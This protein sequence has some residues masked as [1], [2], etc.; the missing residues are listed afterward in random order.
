MEVRCPDCYSSSVV[1]V[2]D[3][4]YYYCEMCSNTFSYPLNEEDYD[5]AS[6]V[7]NCISVTAKLQ[8]IHDYLKDLD[9]WSAVDIDD[10]YEYLRHMD[11]S[12]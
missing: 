2:A 10:L 12:I 6:Y 4:D 9:D 11:D 3:E 1:R 8:W 7:S 5:K